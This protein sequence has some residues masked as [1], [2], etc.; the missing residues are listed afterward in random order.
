MSCWVDPNATPLIL[1]PDTLIWPPGGLGDPT[2]L[3]LSNQYTPAGFPPIIMD[4][5]SQRTRN[6]LYIT[7]HLDISDQG[8]TDVVCL[9]TRWEIST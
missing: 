6:D 8:E 2:E 7:W 1:G 5:P 4:G 9:L 3:S